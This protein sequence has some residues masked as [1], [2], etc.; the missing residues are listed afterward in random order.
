M[1]SIRGC[2][3]CISIHRKEDPDVVG[4][5][6]KQRSIP[7]HHVS[8][9]K[10]FFTTSM[11]SV[12]FVCHAVGT[13][14]MASWRCRSQQVRLKYDLSVSML[15]PKSMM[16]LSSDKEIHSKNRIVAATLY[17]Q[18]RWQNCNRHFDSNELV[19]KT[20]KSYQFTFSIFVYVGIS[21]KDKYMRSTISTLGLEYYG[22]RRETII[23]MSKTPLAH[24][25]KRVS[26]TNGLKNKRLRHLKRKSA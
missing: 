4:M 7:N 5:V 14:R 13:T 21:K 10:T 12:L 22:S 3:L 9:R 15:S 20:T 24:I 18:S 23:L 6:L 17:K 26:R 8:P 1:C 16:M 11:M 2:G 19:L 25:R